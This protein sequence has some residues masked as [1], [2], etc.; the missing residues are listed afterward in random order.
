MSATKGILA[1]L[2][3]N[4]VIEIHQ[5]DG[6]EVILIHDTEGIAEQDIMLDATLLP[7]LNGLNGEHT[8]QSLFDELIREHEELF[9]I[10]DLASFIGA[11]D[12]A[13]LLESEYYFDQKLFLDSD[14]R[15]AI[16]AGTCYPADPAELHTFLEDILQSS[17]PRS[18]PTNAK[19]VVAPHID[20]RVN[21]EIYA[22][23]FNAIRDAEFDVVIHI[24]TSHYGW[25]D[26]FIL[27]EKDFVSPL[28]RLRTDR[29][30]VADIRTRMDHSLT[31]ND[32]A[33]QP[34]HALELHHVF[35]QHMFADREFTVVPVLVTSFQEFVSKQRE[36]IRNDKVKKFC[37]ALKESVEQSGKKALWLVSGDLAHIGRRFG[38]TWD[39]N[40]MLDT[41]R[42]EDFEAMN[43]MINGKAYEYFSTIAR[44]HDRRR[45]C[46]LPPVWTMLQ[47]LQ[48]GKGTALGYEQWDDSPT[49]SAVSFGA[50]A[51][52]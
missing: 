15:P 11:L 43:A 5:H 28:G 44:N 38:D 6:R 8:L 49:G 29:E 26:Q 2:R 27:T 45:I 21:K 12:E 36:P 18:Y 37:A 10:R 34:E 17:P 39:A 41:I 22:A 40:S 52:W 32:A 23:P 9:N 1:P 24:G 20:F 33:H 31:T 4:L 25:Q 30:L 14:V 47:S 19:A 46:G 16:C 7:V 51:W 50:A 3:A 48:P 35:L 42:V 13:C